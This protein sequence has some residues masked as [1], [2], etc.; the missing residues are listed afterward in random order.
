MFTIDNST[1]NICVNALI[2]RAADLQKQV[3]DADPNTAT[4][5]DIAAARGFIEAATALTALKHGAP[6]TLRA[7]DEATRI[8]DAH[9]HR[10]GR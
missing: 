8:I 7:Y 1:R 4:P 3:L 6:N 10:Q 2:H 9:N 5:A